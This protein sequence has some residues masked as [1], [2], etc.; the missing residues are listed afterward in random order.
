MRKFSFVAILIIAFAVFAKDSYEYATI[1][2][3]GLSDIYFLQD[4]KIDI[5]RSSVLSDE[6]PEQLVIYVTQK[7]FDYLQSNGFSLKWFEYPVPKAE[8]F[9]EYITNTGIGEEMEALETQYPDICKRISIGNS[10]Q[11][12][13]IWVMKISDNV[14]TE[15]AEPEFKY[16][17]TM[18]GD[19]VVGMEMCMELI[20]EILEGYEAK[21]D[22]MTYIVDNTELYIMPLHNPDGNNMHQRYNANNVDLNRNFPERVYNDPNTTTGRE[23]E[24]AHMMNW[25]AEHNFIMS[26]NFHGGALVANYPWDNLPGSKKNFREYSMCPDDDTFIY[27][28][29]GYSSRNLPMYNSSSFANG[30]TNGAAWYEAPGCLQDWNYHYHNCMDITL[31][32]SNTKWPSYNQ[33]PQFWQENRDAMLWYL[34]SVNKGI[35]GVVT[36]AVTGNPILATIKIDGIDKDFYTD[37]DFGD[38]YKILE[39]GTYT[40]IVEQEGYETQTIEDIVVTDP[41]N[42]LGNATV[43]NVELE[44]LEDNE[45][46]EITEVSGNAAAVNYAAT[47]MATVYDVHQIEF[48]KAVYTIDGVTETIDMEPVEGKPSSVYTCEIPAQSEVIDGEIYFL[49][50]DE[51]D[52]EGQSEVYDL[53]WSNMLLENFDGSFTLQDWSFGGNSDWEID[54][55]TFSSGTGSA[56]S[57]VITHDQTSEMEITINDVVQSDITF[58]YKVSSENDYDYLQFYVDDT[59]I[60]EWSG[61]IDWTEYSYEVEAGDHTFKWVYEKDGSVTNGDDCGWI[62]AI[63]F[64]M[65]ATSIGGNDIV[66]NNVQL[67]Q[68][69]PNPFNPETTISFSVSANSNVKLS[70]YNAKGEMVKQLLNKDFNKGIHKVN[71]SA[72]KFNSGIYFYKLETGGGIVKTKKMLL[73]K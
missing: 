30:I 69:Y 48:V 3:S 18:H 7:E 31:E 25:V 11:G 9:R 2:I 32:L 62:D 40:L 1:K 23:P 66:A 46:P 57:G 52:N 58:M 20:H 19:E 21:N 6:V 64:P 34:L 65:G 8:L 70:I 12:E 44:P 63:S 33:I 73:V 45:A 47:I 60:E 35:Q 13:P 24:T 54:N 68:N 26:A 36:D 51:L 38:Y 43:V 49:T 28:S 14:D 27:L 17:G 41:D 56:K 15:E 55:S 71:F 10:V 72:E 22:T 29:L 50:K 5:D 37:P 53:T 39:P 61:S 67:Y 4:N 59:K 16:T 42:S